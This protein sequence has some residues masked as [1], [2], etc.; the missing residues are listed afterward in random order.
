M[1]TTLTR[2]DP[3]ADFAAM[4]SLAD[5]LFDQGFNRFPALRNG[6]EELQSTALGID[7][8][9]TNDEYV[10]K[11]LVPGIDPKDVD[12]SVEDD[13]LT[14]KGEF[15]TNDEVNDDSF[16]RRELRYGS[17]QRSLRLPPTVDAEKAQASF[18]H[19]TLKLS[20]PK[21]AEARAKSIKITPHGVIEAPK[22]E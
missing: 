1:A 7:V 19:G 4:R 8:Y 6:G 17:F 12:I 15:S 2:W 9:E 18:E 22:D 21:K 10:V 13:V 16:L 14:I 5:R 11:A 3:F 20:I